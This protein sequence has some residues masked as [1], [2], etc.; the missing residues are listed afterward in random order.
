MTTPDIYPG[1]MSTCIHKDLYRNLKS[2]L[3][4]NSPKL[5]INQMCIHK[6]LDKY[7]NFFKNELLIYATI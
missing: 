2:R 7:T 6:R 3:I 5:E 4:H 1:E